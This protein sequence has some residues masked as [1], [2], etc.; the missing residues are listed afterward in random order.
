VSSN[1]LFDKYIIETKEKSYNNIQ[2]SLQDIIYQNPN[3][4]SIK[5]YIEK[6][7]FSL[8]NP[9]IFLTLEECKFELE[10]KLKIQE[11]QIKSRIA[12]EIKNITDVNFKPQLN[13]F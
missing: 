12:D 6:D 9:N 1:F 4:F 5:V 2:K 3:I 11:E 10:S 8:N 13:K 7:K